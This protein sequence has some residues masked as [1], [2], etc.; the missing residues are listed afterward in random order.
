MLSIGGIV[1]NSL[2]PQIPT[3][4]DPEWKSLMERCWA[5]DPAGRPSFS[6][7]SQKLR[8]MAAAINVKWKYWWSMLKSL[9][10]FSRSDRKMLR[11]KAIVF[12]RSCWL[13]MRELSSQI[14]LKFFVVAVYG[15]YSSCSATTILSYL[16]SNCFPME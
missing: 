7:I 16:Y 12:H 6:E 9:N 11:P 5:S 10:S 8:K 4:C 13:L 2:R 1:N 15:I 14:Y 3:W